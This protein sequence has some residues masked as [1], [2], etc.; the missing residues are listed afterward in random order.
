M[1][2]SETN[3]RK[4]RTRQIA[5]FQSRFPIRPPARRI[6]PVLSLLAVIIL[7]TAGQGNQPM[8]RG[9]DRKEVAGSEE[10]KFDQLV[11]QWLDDSFRLRPLEA[12][13]LGVHTFDDQLGDFSAAGFRAQG[14]LAQK[15]LSALEQI[16]VASLSPPAQADYRVLQGALKVAI[17]DLREVESWKRVPSLYADSPAL[18]IFLMAS[19]EYA[20]LESR[21]GNIIA[22]M[23]RIPEVLEVAKRNLNRPPR[24]WTEI[25]ID[26]TH[27]DIDFFDSFV[28]SLARSAPALGESLVKESK[29]AS[30]AYRQYLKFLEEDLLARSD[31]DFRAGKEN[32]EFYL[33]NSYLLEENSEQLLDMAR[34]L[35][36][37]TKRQIVDVAK[38]IDSGKDWKVVLDE[39]KH[40][41][42]SPNDLMSEY[43]KETERVRAF[44]LKKDLIT[45]PQGDKL[46]IIETPVFERGTIPYAQYY[47][48]APFDK[49]QAGYFT[50]TPIDT[51]RPPEEQEERL[52]GH[53]HG[54]IVNTVVHE[55]YPGHHLQ[56]LYAN[57]LESPLQKVLPSSIFSE[58]WALYSEELVSENGY[59]T[60]E[61]RLI[62][63]Q[64]T[65]VRAARVL[66]D[67]GL[68]VGSMSFDDAVNLLVEQ[69]RLD[70]PGAVSEVRRYTLSPAQPLSYL[71]GREIIFRIRNEYAKK[72]GKKYKAKN[73]HAELL[74]YGALPPTLVEELMYKKGLLAR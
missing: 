43:R 60:P 31:G 58:G 48:P 7:A 30:Q 18:A 34:I 13:A 6:L 11:S 32:F 61:E 37:R 9:S 35:F 27:G 24:I 41:H 51:A 38:L 36:D 17:K 3:H 8:I 52:K 28:P 73:F 63:L 71:V 21:L 14:E 59:Y 56:F 23:Q 49:E 46:Q 72:Q 22:R 64:W 1:R 10:R 26:S 19:R 68:H 66:I 70:K 53:S 67:V 50:V 44:L 69:V 45:I 5:N 54:D 15:Y 47:R 29:R 62:Q 74:S 65:L 39:V 20:P 55:A 2:H 4:L 57:K 16:P 12:T 40:H 25:A 33:K 42:P